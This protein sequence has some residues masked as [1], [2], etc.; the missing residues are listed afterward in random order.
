MQGIREDRDYVV[1]RRI[2]G[3]LEGRHTT[4]VVTAGELA[5]RCNVTLAEAATGLARLGYRPA[6]RDWNR[7][8]R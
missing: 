4:H 2:A 5:K 3:Y 6:R 1:D 8:G 7:I